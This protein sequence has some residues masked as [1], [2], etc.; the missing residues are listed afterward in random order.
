MI[1]FLFRVILSIIIFGLVMSAARSLHAW[2]RRHNARRQA[3]SAPRPE[4]CER[5]QQPEGIGVPPGEIID[6]PYRSVPPDEHSEEA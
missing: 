3:G 4:K 6:V 5:S 2:L 1:V